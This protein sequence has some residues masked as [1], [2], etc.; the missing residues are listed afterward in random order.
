MD[1]QWK[2]F[3]A[4]RNLGQIGGLELPIQKLARGF[5]QNELRLHFLIQAFQTRGQIDREGP[6]ADFIV[7]PLA[8]RPFDQRS[9]Y[10]SREPTAPR[11]PFQPVPKFHLLGFINIRS[12]ME[13]ADE[14][15]TGVFMRR[16]KTARR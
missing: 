8:E 14:L 10:F 16:P 11:A 9:C 13:P 4:H 15:A 7:V 6:G 3:A 12:Q 5:T 2:S 1:H